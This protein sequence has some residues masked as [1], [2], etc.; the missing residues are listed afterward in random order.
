MTLGW[1]WKG[2][3]HEV[4]KVWFIIFIE[5]SCSYL[6]ESEE[7]QLESILYAKR[8]GEGAQCVVFVVDVN[9]LLSNIAFLWWMTYYVSQCR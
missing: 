7:R 8:I 9:L 5:D 6:L 1:G 3:D 2:G 4:V